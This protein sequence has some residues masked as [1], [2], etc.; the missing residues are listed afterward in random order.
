MQYIKKFKE[1]NGE[2]I[3]LYMLLSFLTGMLLG[4]VFSPARNGFAVGS[5]NGSYNEFENSN[6]VE[7]KDRKFCNK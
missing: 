5:Y 1:E 4:L 7:K 6:N 3:I 2:N